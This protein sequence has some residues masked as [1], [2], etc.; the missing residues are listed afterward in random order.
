MREKEIFLLA[1]TAVNKIGPVT[2]KR[3]VE[4]FGSP[5]KPFTASKEELLKVRGV[6]ENVAEEITNMNPEKTANRIMRD[7]DLEEIQLLT[8][9]RHSY[10]TLLKEIY[11]PPPVLYL[12]GDPTYLKTEFK[13]DICLGVVGTRHPTPYG[14]LAAEEIGMS[15][16]ANGITVV[17]GLARGIDTT[18]HKA[19]L[20]GGG[21]TI[22]VLGSGF[23][24]LYPKENKKLAKRIMA[25]GAIVSE[26]P[27]DTPPV[28]ENF[29]RRNRV[30]SGLSEAVVV[31]EAAEK[32][33]ALITANF[34]LNQGRDVFAVPG[35]M[36]SA[37]SAGANNLIREGAT[38]VVSS[39]GLIDQL[40]ERLQAR[41]QGTSAASI[42]ESKSPSLPEE[43]AKKI[44]T[45]I[46]REEEKILSLLSIDQPMHIDQIAEKSFIRI[47]KLLG[48]VLSLEMKGLVEHL[49]GNHYIKKIRI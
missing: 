24:K 35:N 10:P 42:K 44:V 27:P 22:A 33:G 28:S 2:I 20:D 19:A 12:K 3:I 48:T 40:P 43:A 29:P 41:L 45:E 49:P 14:K 25:R 17:S 32:S 16:A 9:Y 23:K 1:L 36:T 7:A 26:F 4:Y 13:D 15:L 11:D 39:R 34:A 5:I 46:D 38:P 8:I 21:R 37:K 30:I 6:T 31:V 18:A 47:N